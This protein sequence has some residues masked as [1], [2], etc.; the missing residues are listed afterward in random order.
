MKIFHL[1]D[2]HIGLMFDKYELSEDQRYIFKKIIEAARTEEPDAIVIAGDIYDKSN[3]S[4]EAMSILNDFITELSDSINHRPIMMISG[5][6]DSCNRVNHFKDL[7]KT[8]GVYL[9][10][11]PPQEP[12]EY[13]EKITLTDDYGPINFYLLPFVNPTMVKLITGI[14]ETGRNFSY[15]IAIK[16]LLERE[17]IDKTVRNVLV[18]H[19][20]FYPKGTN[21]E[22]ILRT[23]TED[24]KVGNIDAVSSEYLEIFD[25]VA[26]GHIHRPDSLTTGRNYIY[27]GTPLACSFS[28]EGQKKGIVVVEFSEKGVKPNLRLIELKPLHEV[29]TITGTFDDVI[30]Q[31]S[32]DYVRIFITDKPEGIAKSDSDRIR[33]FFPRCVDI[34]LC[35]DSNEG[36]SVDLMNSP[37]DIAP[38]EF[39]KMFAPDMTDEEFE[40]IS[41]VL[42]EIGEK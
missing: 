42:N 28:E 31:A 11:L 12:D 32:G 30:K 33:A 16:M 27:C 23:D 1:S 20:F 24:I 39:F 19:Q 21:P 6:H 38:I 40:I 18:S 34:Q 8:S 37:K 2:L 26:L 29:R 3:P 4:A 22:D 13:I 10:G 15:D 7:V 17:N 41:S 14:D 35:D 25:Y 36:P 9:I 5:N